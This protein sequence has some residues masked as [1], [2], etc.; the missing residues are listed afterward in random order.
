M[1]TKQ[2]RKRKW[3][4]WTP[5]TLAIAGGTAAAVLLLSIGTVLLPRT[6]P[7]RHT[8]EIVTIATLQEIINVSELSTFT[9]VYNG[10]AEVMNEESP[11]QI[12]YYVSYEAEVLAGIDFTDVDI[13]FDV[14]SKVITI[15]IPD[16]RINDVL[17]DIASLDY[18]FLNDSANTSS[19]S[20]Q[21]YRACEDDAQTESEAQA[22]I[23]ELA[24]QNA[25]NVLTALV[26]PLLEQ[27]GQE[28][29]LEIQ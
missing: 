11:D 27:A 21:A 5:R 20:Q 19:V 15:T 28:Y 2:K 22:A 3:A 8:P 14:Q 29:T 1:K 23:F 13:S 10:V 26:R 25:Q 24:R 16:V 12:D 17:V 6:A 7:G 9:A 4:K 18:I